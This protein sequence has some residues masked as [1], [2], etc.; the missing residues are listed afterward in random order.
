M[1]ETALARGPTPH[2]GPDRHQLT[3]DVD[4]DLLARDGE[5]V[6]HVREGPALAPETARRVGCDASVVPIVRAGDRVL[7]VGRRTRSIPPQIRRAL[8][9]RDK[10]CRFPGCA[11]RRWVDGHHIE[12]WAKGG[13]TSL[14]NLVL[15]CRHHH[16]LLHEGGYSVKRRAAEGRLDFRR[17]DG[18]E[19]PVSPPLPPAREPPAILTGRGL[20][21]TA[22]ASRWIWR[23]ASTRC[24][25]RPGTD[26]PV[27]VD[28]A[29]P[30]VTSSSIQV[31]VGDVAATL[32]LVAVAVAVSFWRRA[33]LERDIGI[34]VVRSAIQLTAI[35]YVIKFIF[36][37][38]SLWFV[39]AL[40]A[41]MVV[42]GA[43][44]ARSRAKQVPGA[45]WPLLG[46][47]ALAAAGTLGLVVALG[48]FDPQPR[49]LVPVGGMVV[50]NSMTAAAVALNRL[51]D[52][53]T[54]RAREL[55]AT[56][57][58]GATSTQAAAPIVRRSLRSGMITLVDSTKTTGLIFFPGT[59]VGMLLAGASPTDAVRLQ[60]ILLWTLLGS[61][62]LAALFAVS[63]AY[64]NFFTAAHQLRDQPA[65]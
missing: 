62:A 52:E 23:R 32:A 41:V 38:D 25:R 2:A 53:V 30:P 47:L 19:I 31:S 14:D 9:A 40:I 3:V 64:R 34:A 60:L 33:D 12:H 8:E 59:M 5:G 28:R 49:F 35:G 46:A 56:L 17:P 4:L 15:L 51:G 42:F 7:S 16:R 22:P 58:L 63:L 54:A 50:G 18:R 43:L 13:E 36:D 44:Q 11:N 57:A 48:V 6:V 45:F 37:Q 20:L 61:V 21:M 39:F 55:E 10:G 26:N 1:A 27:D 24:S 29:P 65:P